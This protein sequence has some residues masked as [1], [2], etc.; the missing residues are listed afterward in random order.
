MSESNVPSF[1]AEANWIDGNPEGVKL[2]L[3]GTAILYG[4]K[5]SVIYWVLR[6]PWMFIRRSI[7]W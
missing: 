1:L 3:K 4:D 2:G 6:K 5:V 7:G